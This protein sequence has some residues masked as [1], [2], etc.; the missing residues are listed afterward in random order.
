MGGRHPPRRSYPGTCCVGG[1][2]WGAIDGIA[3]LA[4]ALCKAPALD[5]LGMQAQ[6]D[7][8][9]LMPAMV[10]GIVMIVFWVLLC[11]TGCCLGFRRRPSAK[12]EA[13][14]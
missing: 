6:F 9:V 1:F 14:G 13:Q 3:I 11:C 4:K 8:P 12:R 7:E 2:V 10:L 5:A